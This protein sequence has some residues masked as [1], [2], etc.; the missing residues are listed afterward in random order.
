MTARVYSRARAWGCAAGSKFLCV[1]RISCKVERVVL[2]C[3]RES[4]FTFMILFDLD[5]SLVVLFDAGAVCGLSNN[6]VLDQP[7]ESLKILLPA[8]DQ[9]RQL[10]R[11]WLDVSFPPTRESA[12]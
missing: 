5:V 12:G 8:V 10:L 11:S 9:A 7:W 3:E 6:R 1:G 4:A 2:D